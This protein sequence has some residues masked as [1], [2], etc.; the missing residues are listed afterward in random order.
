MK[1]WGE[2]E[3]NGDFNYRQALQ[4]SWMMQACVSDKLIEIET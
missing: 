4:D 2:G 3:R 1:R